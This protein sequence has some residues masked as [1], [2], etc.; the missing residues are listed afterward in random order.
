MKYS[1]MI[2]D[3]GSDYGASYSTLAEAQQDY[4][5]CC[6]EVDDNCTEGMVSLV[7]DQTGEVLERHVV[8]VVDG[9]SDGISPQQPLPSDR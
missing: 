9:F 1:V 4:Q 7:D 3:T 5:A 6:R 8:G 2:S